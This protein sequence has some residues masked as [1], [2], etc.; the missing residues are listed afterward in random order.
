[1]DSGK[2][3][4]APIV[5]TQSLALKPDGLPEKA[6]KKPMKPAGTIAPLPEKEKS[7]VKSLEDQVVPISD[8]FETGTGEER[9]TEAQPLLAIN[10]PSGIYPFSIH[11][12]SYMNRAD[13]QAA[14]EVYRK[15]GLNA[16]WVQI[17]LG[18]RGIWYRI[19]IG[20]FQNAQAA[21]DVIEK[22]R[23]EGARSVKTV[24][25]NFIGAFSTATQLESAE[26]TLTDKGYDSYQ[27]AGPDGTIFLFTGAFEKKEDADK[28]FSGLNSDGIP[29]QVVER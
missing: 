19:F 3:I 2:E 24:Y 10:P 20:H 18:N 12:A 28:L 6:V 4:E 17:D 23:L 22:K 14:T 26:K 1:M 27:I 16:Y 29:S 9:K 11:A 13:A 5:S 7:P 15:A 25:A 8:G 21:Q